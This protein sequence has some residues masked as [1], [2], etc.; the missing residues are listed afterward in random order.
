VSERVPGEPRSAAPVQLRPRLRSF[1]AATEV[2]LEHVTALRDA[3]D[4]IGRLGVRR[5]Q[6]PGDQQTSERGEHRHGPDAR[7]RLRLLRRPVVEERP[8]HPDQARIE[9]DAGPGQ[10]PDLAEPQPRVSGESE[11]GPVALRRA[12]RDEEIDR[13]GVEGRRCAARS[14][15][16][17]APIDTRC[18]SSV[19]AS[20]GQRRPS[21][22]E[23]SEALG[24]F[25]PSKPPADPPKS[26]RKPP[27]ATGT[28]VRARIRSATTPLPTARAREH[29]PLDIGSR[30]H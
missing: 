19:P 25:G 12:S 7:R 4:E 27:V 9:V 11:R 30:H 28:Y 22:Q 16:S 20:F 21:P 14:P 26:A 1:E 6:L 10:P 8:P 23:S 18:A 29:K 5:A 15:A 17:A 3:G 24:R 13:G 2:A